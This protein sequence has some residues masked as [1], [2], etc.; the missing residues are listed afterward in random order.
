[1]L[2]RVTRC[3]K[4]LVMAGM[5]ACQSDRNA[6]L[7]KVSP[8][9]MPFV[10]GYMEAHKVD[11]KSDTIIIIGFDSARVSIHSEPMT[12]AMA[13][14]IQDV[15]LGV[16]HLGKYDLYFVGKPNPYIYQPTKR[17]AR[18]K[19]PIQREVDGPPPPPP[20]GYNYELWELRFQGDS[21]ISYSPKE[22]IDRYVQ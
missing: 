3:W 21:V 22:R 10:K 16:E 6:G 8:V 17:P 18:S 5:S 12:T 1:M 20:P 9:L 7:E 13:T 15:L 11:Q 4:L 19:P 14:Q 2:E